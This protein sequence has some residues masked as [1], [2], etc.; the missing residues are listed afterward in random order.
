MIRRIFIGL[1]GVLLLVNLAGAKKI[2]KAGKIADGTYIDSEFGFSFEVPDEWDSSIKKD[3]S[4]VRIAL[5]KKEYDIPLHFQHVPSYTTIPKITVYADTTSLALNQFID[6]LLSD[7]YSTS[8]K[9]NILGEFKILFGDFQLK[10]N[11]K[12]IV[13]DLAGWKISGEQKYTVRVTSSGNAGDETSGSF[14]EYDVITDFYGGSVF[15]AKYGK[16]IIMMHFICEA[17]YF[18]SMD[19]EFDDIVKSFKFVKSEG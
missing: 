2:E 19:L 6:S 16:T 13:G 10:K 12:K 8:Q 1:F 7:K 18:A 14:G 5:T 9:K 17:R 15:F 3:K 4:A 11:A